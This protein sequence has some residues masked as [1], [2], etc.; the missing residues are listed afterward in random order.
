MRKS[1]RVVGRLDVIDGAV[2]WGRIVA[3]N[4]LAG[5]MTATPAISGGRIYVRTHGALYAI[6][7]K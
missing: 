1:I 2:Q 6:G 4:Q 3:E 7:Q 5:K